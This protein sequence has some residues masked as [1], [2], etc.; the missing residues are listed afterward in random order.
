VRRRRG[1]QFLGWRDLDDV[2]DTH[3]DYMIPSEDAT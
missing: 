2:V 3:H 1:E